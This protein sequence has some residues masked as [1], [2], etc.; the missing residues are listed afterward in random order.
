M[1]MRLFTIRA[2]E[3]SFKLI[4]WLSAT[5]YLKFNSI[6]ALSEASEKIIFL[7]FLITVFDCA[8]FIQKKNIYIYIYIY[9]RFYIIF[10][11]G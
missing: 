1:M 4:S 9:M 10:L 11:N 8:H 3:Q 2:K 6:S 7:L 5:A